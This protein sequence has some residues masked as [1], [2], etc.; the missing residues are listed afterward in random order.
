M[1]T[2]II[3]FS[4][5]YRRS[6]VDSVF[7]FSVTAFATFSKGLGEICLLEVLADETDVS[8][9]QTALGKS[10]RC[11][12]FHYGQERRVWF[13]K[14]M[15]MKSIASS[16]A[17]RGRSLRTFFFT[18]KEN[19]R[20]PIFSNRFLEIAFEIS[21]MLNIPMLPHWSGWFVAELIDREILKRVDSFGIA[22]WV[23]SGDRNEVLKILG[24]LI[25]EGKLRA[26]PPDDADFAGWRV[27]SFHDRRRE[28]IE[29]WRSRRLFDSKPILTPQAR[30]YFL[31]RSIESFEVLD[32][33]QSGEGQAVQPR[34]NRRSLADLR[35]LSRN[36]WV[37]DGRNFRYATRH[38]V[39]GKTITCLTEAEFKDVVEKPNFEKIV[40]KT[41]ITLD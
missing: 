41:L 15:E 31:D 16:L 5:R 26:D 13:P 34:V 19:R 14:G 21:R 39:F 27:R 37:T 11:S 30:Q 2:P 17:G 25:R 35:F 8:R 4:T 20:L 40:G 23:C 32:R 6:N 22:A 29:R 33:H 7:E 9:L 3:K 28:W 12:L 24:C 1:E 18:E 38:D 10:G 36:G